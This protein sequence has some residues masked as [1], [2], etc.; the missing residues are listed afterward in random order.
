MRPVLLI[1]LVAASVLPAWSQDVDHVAVCEEKTGELSRLYNEQLFGDAVVLAEEIVS[2]SKEHLGDQHRRTLVAYLNLGHVH[3]A[4]G[5]REQALLSWKQSLAVADAGGHD[6][7]GVLANLV[8]LCRDQGHPEAAGFAQRHV[9]LIETA[10]G[11]ESQQMIDALAALAR[12]HE[13]D[14]HAAEAEAVLRRRLDLH[15][16]VHGRHHYATLNAFFDLALFLGAMRSDI[17]GSEAVARECL[18]RHEAAGNTG[19][20]VRLILDHIALV[21]EA[22]QEYTE[23]FALRQRAIEDIKAAEGPDSY[24]LASHYAGLANNC[25]YRELSPQAAEYLERALELNVAKYGPDNSMTAMARLDLADLYRDLD[26]HA[27]ADA[28][29]TAANAVLNSE[30]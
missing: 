10:H 17:D 2:Y 4:L 16:P 25:L 22:R 9:E 24:R 14:G 8:P 21:L 30:G 29:E 1:L 15:D 27:E 3:K 5:A 18:Q 28:L 12:I 23:A 13:N 20:A 7:S 11:A 19:P 26:R 6:P